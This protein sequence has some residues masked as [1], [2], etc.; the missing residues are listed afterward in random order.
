MPNDQIP[1]FISL[2]SGRIPESRW[3][4]RPDSELSMPF[5]Q[6]PSPEKQQREGSFSPDELFV[7]F[8]FEIIRANK[9]FVR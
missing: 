7:F 4:E 5:V 6:T 1:S 2:S 9:V 8:T 3:F